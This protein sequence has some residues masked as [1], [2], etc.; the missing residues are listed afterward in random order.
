MPPLGIPYLVG[1]PRKGE[2][3]GGNHGGG[4]AAPPLPQPQLARL[5]VG[6]GLEQ[7]HAPCPFFNCKANARADKRGGFIAPPYPYPF[8]LFLLLLP[9]MI[10]GVDR[11]ELRNRDLRI[12]LR[13]LN[14]GV[15]QELLQMPQ[16][17]AVFEHV[18]GRS[19][20]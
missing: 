12:N 20:A 9:R 8:P 18:R 14:R 16:R 7:G 11:L 5:R 15:A 17:G 10:P 2:S 19:M 3:K 13:G 6:G 4:G 1:A